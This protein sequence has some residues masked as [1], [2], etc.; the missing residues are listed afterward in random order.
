[1]E[2]CFDGEMM[3]VQNDLFLEAISNRLVDLASREFDE[4]A[5]RS[6]ATPHTEIL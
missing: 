4:A 6:Q 2:F 5:V 3:G 1:M